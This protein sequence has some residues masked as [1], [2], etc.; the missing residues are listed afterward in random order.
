M[1]SQVKEYDVIVAGAGPAGSTIG[2]ELSRMGHSVLVLEKELLPRDKLCA[3][4]IPRR[5]LKLIDLPDGP[6][7]ED[8]INKVEFTFRPKG[9]FVLE[10]PEP[11]LY[12]V[13]R[14]HFD[15]MLIRRAQTAGCQVRDGEP[16]SGLDVE[17]KRVLV[18]TPRRM[19]Q[20]RV[21]VGAD[22]VSGAVARLAGFRRKRRIIATLQSDVPMQPEISER[23]RGRVWIGFGWIRKGYTWIF[24]KRN[25]L[26]V[27]IG[28][29]IGD[30][31]AKALRKAF[32]ALVRSFFPQHQNAPVASFPISLGGIRQNLVRERMLLVGEA[33]NLVHPLTAEGIYFAVRSA[34]LAAETVDDFLY[35]RITTLWPYQRRV[36]EEMG[37]FFRK[38]RIFSGLFYGL[39]RTSFRIF[40]KGNTK[41]IRYFGMD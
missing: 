19:F 12:T 10:S 18:H 11:L 21:L 2:Y 30:G 36:D 37:A 20:A 31:E 29:T 39:P 33:A 9:R 6:M 40:V 1:R 32:Q 16:V 24:P 7:I 8:R 15:H 34:H 14:R 23:Y 5:I 35:G 13:S 25:H 17:K 28:A 26:S 27:G 38:S 41:L 22:G 4:G 3:G